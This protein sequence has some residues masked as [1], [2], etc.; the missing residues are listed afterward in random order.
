[1]VS[2][3]P[4]RTRSPISG[5]L[6][7]NSARASRSDQRSR[8]SSTMRKSVSEMPTAASGPVARVHRRGPQLQELVGLPFAQDAVDLADQAVGAAIGLDR[9]DAGGLQRH[10]KVGQFR[11]SGGDLG[12]L[13]HAL[14]RGG[15]QRIDLLAH[16]GDAGRIG[17]L[18]RQQRRA[19]LREL[20]AQLLQ[21]R[22]RD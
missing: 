22:V 11:P 14:G 9:G 7:R 18:R 20:G 6:F 2:P 8:V 1:M 12:G 21:P 3:A 10:Q 17:V 5:R 13:G 19:P 15:A 16:G 4:S